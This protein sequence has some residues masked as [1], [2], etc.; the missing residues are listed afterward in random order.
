ME[1]KALHR[2]HVL[3]VLVMVLVGLN[4][5]PQ[6]PA[7]ERTRVI[8]PIQTEPEGQTYGRWAAEL[9]QWALGSPEA[10]VNPVAD[11]TGEF[12]AQRQVDKV[13][14]LAGSSLYCPGLPDL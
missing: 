6:S 11:P 9:W 3:T 13:W 2:L 12:C 10:T 7:L 14:F 5:H 1:R 4:A 8:A